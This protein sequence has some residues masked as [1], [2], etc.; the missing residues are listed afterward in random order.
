MK[1]SLST[2]RGLT[3]KVALPFLCLLLAITPALVSKAQA[4]DKQTVTISVKQA[5]I[6][7]VFRLVEKQTSFR[8]LFDKSLESFATRVSLQYKKVP[9]SQLLADIDKQTGLQFK[10]SGTTISVAV[11]NKPSQVHQGV[12]APKRE[13][14]GI[15]L[16]SAGQ[17]MVG[18]T[19]AVKDGRIGTGTDVNGKYI[20]SVPEDAT[21]VFSLIGYRK[22]EMPVAGKDKINVILQEASSSLEEVVVV[23][24]GEQKKISLVGA[25]AT[26]SPKDLKQPVSN[27]TNS[28][29]GRIAGMVSVQRSGELGSNDANIYIRGISTFTQG[30]SAPLTLVDGV[31]RNIANVDPEDIESFSVLKDASATAVYGVRGANGVILITTKSGKAGKPSYNVR[32]TEGITQFAKLP[33]FT[34]GP[35]YMEISNEALKTRGSVPIYSDEAI[36]KTRDG[37]DPYLYPNVNWFKELFRDHGKVR[38]ANANISGGS[39]KAVYYIGL[40]YF[41]ELGLYNVDELTKYNSSIYSKRYNVTSNIT[42]TPSKTTTVKLGIQGYLNNVNQPATSV[43]GIFSDAY[44]L[45]PVQIPV[46]YPDGKIADV[47]SSGLKNAWAALTQTGYANQWKSQLYSNLRLTQQLPF[48]TKGLS[49]TGMFSFDT[50][51]YTTNRYSKTPDTWLATG[52]DADGKLIYEQTFIGTEYL[53]YDGKTNNAGERTLY[54][55]LAVNYNRSFGKHDVSGMLLY[56]KSDKANSYVET[57]ESSLPYRFQGLAGRFTYGFSNKYFAELNFGYNGSENFYPDKRYGFFPSAGLGWVVSE[58]KFFNPVKDYVQLFKVRFSHGLVGNSNIDGRRFAYLATVANT[59]EYNF[60]K[61]MDQKYTGKEIGEYAVDVQWETSRKT[62][63]GFD[64]QV[65]DESLSLQVDLFKEYRSGIF[66]RRKSLPGYIGMINAPFGNV[67]I[68]DNKGLD[69]SVTYNRRFGDVSVQL[70]GNFTYNKNKVVENDDPAWK[71]PWLE[72]KGLKVGQRFGYIALGLFESDDDVRNSPRQP[73]DV[74]AGDIKY[75]DINGD[76]V[77]DS[78]D[79]APIG[80]GD[81]PEIIYGFGFTVGYKSLS[82]SAL[83]QGAAHVDALLTGEG[84]MP[85]QQGLARGNLFDNITDRWTEANPRQDA[86]YPRM[87]AGSLNDNY[88]A[89]TWW[90]KRSDYLRLKTVQLNYSLPQRWLKHIGLKSSSIFLQGV[91]LLTFSPFKM[92][93]VEVGNGR[94]AA[95]SSNKSYTVGIAVNF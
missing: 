86:F 25:Q 10:T 53:T 49:V 30:L 85:F 88:A 81:I 15:V 11:K 4:P 76:G 41:D 9:V 40:G 16:D 93:D 58:E 37:S 69:A 36:Q 80:Y 75:K 31:P 27:L 82:L 51:N 20:L 45:T 38:N 2:I 73:G 22:Q 60:G 64:I 57:L 26:I 35:T 14:T 70:L 3:K 71:Y 34:D 12:D 18:V 78:Y 42:L 55:E 24:Y 59:G 89:S 33:S 23:G 65:L 52:R 8:F 17:A 95:Y 56:N 47:R 1:L 68:I 61:T 63:L 39:E 74:R 72:R 48:I 54:N 66:L 62:N 13:I 79:Q 77:I 21:L 19:V 67:G 50:Y 32:Y 28:L 6:V 87:M 92:W 46:R 91:N 5:T 7:E 29:G 44:Y 90:V 83:F 43:G 94:G 84:T